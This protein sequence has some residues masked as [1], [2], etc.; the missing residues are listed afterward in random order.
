MDRATELTDAFVEVKFASYEAYRTGIARRT[1]NPIWNEDFRCNFCINAVEVSNDSD[2]QN[3]PLEIKVMDYDTITYND[4]IG[5]VFI[6]LNSLLSW[7]SQSQI[8]GYFP[9]F[10]TCK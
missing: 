1:L 6:D 9:I 5:S 8:S 10:D 2:L 7:E 4:A 3:E